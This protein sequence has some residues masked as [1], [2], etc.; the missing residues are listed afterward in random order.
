MPKLS[1]VPSFIL[2]LIG[3]IKRAAPLVQKLTGRLPLCPWG[4]I[5]SSLDPRTLGVHPPEINIQVVETD[6]EFKKL[7]FGGKHEV[8]FPEKIKITPELWNEYLVVFWQNPVNGH[9]Y[10]AQKTIVQSGD[11][12]VDCGCCE[13]FF[14]FQA[15]EAGAAKVIGI[16]PNPVM[17]RCLEK[18]FA[19][20]IKAGRVIICHNAVGAHCGQASF[21]FDLDSP[22]SG[23][24][25]DE[26]VE[27][28]AIATLPTIIKQL[29]LSRLDFIKMDIEGM[30]I[31]ALEGAL[32]LLKKDHPKLAITTYHRSFDYMALH[33]LVM[34]AGYRQIKPAG[35][36][37]R[38]DGIYRPVL[39]QA[40]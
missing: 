18:T 1:I 13:G 28:V 25:G 36:T 7:R 34:A 12:C 16:E 5:F 21:T 6:R 8:W 10:F 31:Q 9:Y 33:V 3:F 38:D 14:V 26:A 15:L 29:G 30:E 19:E 2:K 32:P 22:A 27:L 11:I 4:S 35:L 17:V 39:L 20:E 24:I 40:S 23:R 37:R